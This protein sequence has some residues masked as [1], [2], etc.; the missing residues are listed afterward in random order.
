[1]GRYGHV[2]ES[3]REATPLSCIPKLCTR[4]VSSNNMR[5]W[6]KG[7]LL[8]AKNLTK[9]TLQNV[10]CA[11]LLQLNLFSEKK[12]FLLAVNWKKKKTLMTINPSEGGLSIFRCMHICKVVLTKALQQNTGWL[13]HGDSAL[14]LSTVVWDSFLI[15]MCSFLSSQMVKAQVRSESKKRIQ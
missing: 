15:F 1:M 11:G 7:A 5:A 3:N 6:L 9:W 8:T 2:C 14:L 13:H 4:V 10:L 12:H